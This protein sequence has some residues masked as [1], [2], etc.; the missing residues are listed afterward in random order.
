MTPLPVSVRT[1]S[2]ADDAVWS[3]PLSSGKFPVRQ[4]KYREF[5]QFERLA[6]RQLGQKPRIYKDLGPN[7][8]LEQNREFRL[9]DQGILRP[10]QGTCAEIRE[11]KDRASTILRILGALL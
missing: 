8:L 10:I 4:G 3:E 9:A 6:G 1:D 2:L 11:S 5:R 7:S